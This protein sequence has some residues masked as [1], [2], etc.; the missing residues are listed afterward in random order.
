MKAF[1]FVNI[2]SGFIKTGIF[3]YN[4]YIV[5]DIIIKPILSVISNIPVI[6]KIF[7]LTC[8]MQKIY[9][10]IFICTIVKKLILKNKRFTA[11]YDLN[12]YIIWS[13]YIAFKKKKRKHQ[14]D[15]YLNLIGKEDSGFQF[16]FPM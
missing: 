16:F 1:I 3:L 10:N 13:L 15:K 11:Q 5:L 9:K 2:I 14:Q 6:S 8:Y 7:I 12:K 4:P